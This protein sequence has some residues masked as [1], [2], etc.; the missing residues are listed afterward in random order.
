M[1][2]LS[3]SI[4]ISFYIIILAITLVFAL[5]YRKNKIIKEVGPHKYKVLN[6]DWLIRITLLVFDLLLVILTITSVVFEK[7]LKFAII[8]AVISYLIV[9]FLI[10]LSEI[11]TTYFMLVSSQDKV[12]LFYRNQTAAF[13]ASHV[14]FQMKN[15]HTL[16]YYKDD[17]VFD[18]KKKVN[19]KISS[20]R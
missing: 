4:I 20:N 13:D 17:L 15:G 12:Y 5:V 6:H 8:V 1:S 10:L 7:E 3:R 9:G 2:I 18:T 14:H 11:Y 19:K 16:M